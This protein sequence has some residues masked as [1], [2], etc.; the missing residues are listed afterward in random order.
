MCLNNVS[1]SIVIEKCFMVVATWHAYLQC[2]TICHY[3]VSQ[4]TISSR[5]CVSWKDPNKLVKG[6]TS[7][8]HGIVDVV[9]CFD[10]SE[11]NILSTNTCQYYKGVLVKDVEHMIRRSEHSLHQL[12]EPF[13]WKIISFICGLKWLQQLQ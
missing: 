7:I 12:L 5:D 3:I 11:R 4:F 2:I 9:Q 13:F 6:T 10:N 1:W 8:F